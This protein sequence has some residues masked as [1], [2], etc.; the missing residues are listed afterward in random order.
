[1]FSITMHK[2]ISEAD[3]GI[4]FRWRNVKKG[5]QM[6]ALNPWLNPDEGQGAILRILALMASC[7]LCMC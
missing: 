5:G 7:H 2:L 6:D 1:M 4:E 3:P